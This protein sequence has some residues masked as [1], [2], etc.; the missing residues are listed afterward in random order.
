[1]KIGQLRSLL[2]RYAELRRDAGDGHGAASVEQLVNELQPFDTK[3]VKALSA[4][5][6][7]SQTATK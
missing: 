5:I 6:R 4:S 3:T 2:A 1:M 7:K